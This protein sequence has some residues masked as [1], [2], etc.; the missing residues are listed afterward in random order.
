MAKAAPSVTSAVESHSAPTKSQTG[1]GLRRVAG[2][3]S[4]QD[5]S[6]GSARRRA[7]EA[8]SM[9]AIFAFE[10]LAV[11]S[12]QQTGIVGIGRPA[13]APVERCRIA[14][15]RIGREKIEWM[16]RQMIRHER[17]LRVSVFLSDAAGP[18]DIHP[19]LTLTCHGF[20]LF[21]A[22]KLWAA[23]HLTQKVQ[24]SALRYQ[25]GP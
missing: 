9:A 15:R 4:T 17:H 19:E 16:I 24:P 5:S 10:V 8:R 7:A 13:G 1:R 14:R 22:G 2:G 18:S 3:E 25:I 21:F 12:G 6:S 11:G 20:V 23:A